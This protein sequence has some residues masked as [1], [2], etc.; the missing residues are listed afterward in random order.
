MK[1]KKNSQEYQTGYK[2]NWFDDLKISKHHT[3]RVIEKTGQS[4]DASSLVWTAVGVGLGDCILLGLMNASF[5]P[6]RDS[7]DVTQPQPEMG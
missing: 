6:G 4:C 2:Q 7:G 5:A 1:K 3:E